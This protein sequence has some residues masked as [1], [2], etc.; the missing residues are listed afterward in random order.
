MKKVELHYAQVLF[1]FAYY[2]QIDLSLDRCRWESLE[3]LDDYFNSLLSF[4][5]V[6]EYLRTTFSISENELLFEVFIIQK[7]NRVNLFQC[8][9]KKFVFDR[10][11]IIFCFQLLTKLK[12]QLDSQ[13]KEYSLKMEAIRLEVAILCSNLKDVILERDRQ[14]VLRVDFFSSNRPKNIKILEFL[15]I[16]FPRI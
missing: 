4:E 5:K 12:L 13:D 3:V 15:P 7:R 10:N 6:K 2:R 11:D 1:L 14:K 9:K 8:F 16:D